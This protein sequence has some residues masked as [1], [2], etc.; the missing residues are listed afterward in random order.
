MAKKKAAGE[1][2]RAANGSGNISKRPDGRYRL[3]IN[4]GTNPATGKPIRKTVYGLS[5]EEALAKAR[6]I[7]VQHDEGTYT[8]PSKL[9]VGQWL[10]VWHDEYL[11]NV[12][13]DT[14]KQY[15]SYIRVHLK[16][17]LG[18]VK[19]SALSPH[20]V[21][22]LCNKAQRSTDDKKGLSAK[23]V[24]NMCGILH[25]AME[26]AVSLSYIKSNPTNSVTMPRIERREMTVIKDDDVS[27]FLEA[28]KGDAYECVYLMDLF[29][30]LRLGEILGLRWACADFDKGTIFVEKQLKRRKGD[31]HYLASLKTDRTRTL[32]PSAYVMNLLRQQR[33]RQREQQLKAGG[34]YKNAM[35][36]VFTNDTGGHLVGN[37]VY[38]HL[39]AIVKGL[40]LDAV[41]F[42]DLRHSF[43]LLSLQNGDDIKTLQ[44]N[45]GHATISTTLNI[46]GHVSERM[47][48]ESAAKMDAYIGTLGL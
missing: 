17:T 14:A 18:H 42:H 46:Y 38:K 24:R 26:K 28:I 27:R 41:R 23:S 8:E 32:T 22:A 2:K 25:A 45:M 44:E 10:D 34:A 19:L 16:P 20:M 15:E 29:T 48:A 11:G 35:G 47:K 31:T 12:K 39:K 21:Q 7:Q 40:G 1:R 4:L 37:T 30:G 6:K 33:T 3:D 13:A 5:A 9:T 36:L 43:A